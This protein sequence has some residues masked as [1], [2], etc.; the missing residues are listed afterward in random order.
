[1]ALAQLQSVPDASAIV[2]QL[3]MLGLL[4]LLSAFMS[5]SEVALLGFS[6]VRRMQ[7]VD[8]GHA[9]IAAVERVMAHPDRLLI[10]ILIGNIV[11]TATAAALVTIFAVTTFGDWAISLAIGLPVQQGRACRP[12]SVSHRRRRCP[13]ASRRSS[14]F[15]SLSR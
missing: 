14:R 2:V 15:P 4:V 13:S 3:L 9:R 12:P 8:E 11:A 1:M 5:G 6:R 10:A 7:L